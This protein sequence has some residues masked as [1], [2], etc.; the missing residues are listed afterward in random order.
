MPAPTRAPR[1]ALVVTHPIQHFA[2]LYRE[3]AAAGELDLRVF[4]CCDWGIKAYF[5]ELYGREVEWDV[6]LL[7]GYAHEFL[8]IR[9]R[10]RRISF[11]EVD[12]PAVA[13]RLG[14]FAPDALLVHGYGCRTMWRAVRWAKRWGVPALLSSDSNAGAPVAAWKRPLKRLL[15]GRFYA[16]LAGAL[17]VGGNNRAY[18]REFG[19]PDERIFPGVLPA[20]GRRL[21]AGVPDPAA[22]RREV[23]ASLDLPEGAVVALF[24][25]NLTPWKRADDLVAAAQAAGPPVWAL[26]VGD[27]PER[28][29]VESL[30][31]AGAGRVRFAGF[32]NQSAIPRYYAAADLLVVPS[33][34]DAHP[35]VVTE[36]LFFGLPIVVS[37]ALGCI[38]PGDTAQ[39]GRNAIVF[40]RGNRRA[41]AGLLASLAGSPD[42]RA[43][44]GE[45]SQAIAREHD[46]PEAA[47]LL[48]NAV[49]A[50]VRLG[51]RS[52][53]VAA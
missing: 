12:N 30:A 46:A 4:F 37:D 34:R 21:L 45:A 35:L 32:V 24:C 47:R 10:P 53:G 20:D 18:H 29:R 28:T 13:A 48:A 50:A 25:G 39:V 17:A 41:L 14:A 51:P 15:V 31:A 5:D 9:R 19:L 6:P 33:E 43:Q 36:A 3:V 40:P 38:G 8:P 49:R 42:R 16:G 52:A 44:L 7:E 23:R 22:A 26:V 11:F 2:P 1:L 27:G